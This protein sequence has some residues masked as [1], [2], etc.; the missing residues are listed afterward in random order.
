MNTKNMWIAILSGAAVSLL[1]ANVPLLNLI[2]I[3]LC[4]GFWVSAVFAVWLYR[5]LNGSVTLLEGLKIGA[6]SGLI[7]WG[8]GFLLSFVGLA[9]IQG[10]VNGAKAF[11]PADADLGTNDLPAWGAILFNLLGVVFEVFF[12]LIGGLIGGAIFRTDRP[13]PKKENKVEV[14][15]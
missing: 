12:G 6:M 5:R 15:A 11:L 9:G 7:A 1:L 4:A 10:L 3:L 8:I 13:A 14:Q 2:N